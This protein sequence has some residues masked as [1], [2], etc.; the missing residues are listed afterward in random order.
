MKKYFIF[1]AAAIVAASCAKTPAPVQTPD[2]PEAPAVEGKVAVEF[3]SNIVTNVA[4]KLNGPVESWNKQK[5]Y[6]Y[7]FQRIK[8][9]AS[10]N[11]VKDYDNPFIKC[12]ESTAPASENEGKINVYESANTP[13]YYNQSN[14]YDFY[15]F[16]V[17]NAATVASN[18]NLETGELK[19]KKAKKI[20]V[21][22]DGS[23]DLMYAYADPKASVDT[24]IRRGTAFDG[25]RPD[26]WQDIYAFSAYAARRGVHPFMTFKHALTRINVK[27]N[28]KSTFTQKVDVS[29]NPLYATSD[30]DPTETT[31]DTS[32][33]KILTDSMYVTKVLVGSWTK[34]DFYVAG[35]TLGLNLATKADSTGLVMKQYKS[36][37]DKTL[38]DLKK[39]GVKPSA[40][41]TVA[42]EFVPVGCGLMVFPAKTLDIYIELEQVIPGS[43]NKATSKVEKVLKM[44]DVH[45][46]YS[47][48]LT[49]FAAGYQFDINLTV[50]GLEQVDIT[51]E[52]T[53]WKT[54]GSFEID[55]DE[56]PEIF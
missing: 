22:I 17:D 20:A 49:E 7:G 2:G 46:N 28:S 43:A 21:T 14:T 12:V 32:G 33:L 6:I 39:V 45:F 41:G 56:E 15:G 55:T 34:A 44:D 13:Y 47:V 11:V 9:L 30:T 16:Y 3:S 51:A 19:G 18:D 1:A 4:T 26:G 10:G 50:Y 29:G 35:D 52:L 48:G 24:A 27:V 40:N 5:L 54:G 25:S 36:E 23:Q 37:S 8:D 53:P 31:S 42:S 38:V